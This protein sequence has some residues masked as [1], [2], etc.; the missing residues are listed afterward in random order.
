MRPINLRTL[1]FNQSKTSHKAE[2]AQQTIT[3]VDRN[4]GITYNRGASD[5]LVF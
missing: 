5:R 1:Y 3:Y 2:N 4:C